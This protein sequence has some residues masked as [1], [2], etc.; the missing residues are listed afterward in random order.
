MTNPWR[1]AMLAVLLMILAG[2]PLPAQGRTPGPPNP[3]MRQMIE[4]RFAEHVQTQLNL[5]EAQSAQVR[6]ILRTSAERRRGMENDERGALQALREQLR[7]GVAAQTDSLS[8]LLDHLT[9]L[10]VA[11]A[12]AAR[13]EL[14]ELGAVLTPVQQAQF[15]LM[16][17]RIQAAAQGIRMQRRPP[18][19]PRDGAR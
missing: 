6:R 9:S 5:T 11:Q 19:P 16:R 18:G 13:D 3:R 15:L 17:D 2:G 10:R 8:R 12:Q 7:P 4:E 14:R 1:P